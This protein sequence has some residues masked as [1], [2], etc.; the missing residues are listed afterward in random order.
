MVAR[1]SRRLGNAFNN[2]LQNYQGLPWAV[3]PQLPVPGQ[4]ET[5]Q[6]VNYGVNLQMPA[7]TAESGGCDCGCNDTDAAPSI[8][9]PFGVPW[10]L[11]LGGAALLAYPLLKKGS[12]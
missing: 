8:P 11:W 4:V 9:D 5:S 12:R 3:V 2:P 10:W 7:A 6:M 1:K